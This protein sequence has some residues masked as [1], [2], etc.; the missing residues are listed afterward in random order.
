M[1][2]KSV[3]GECP[4][5]NFSDLSIICTSVKSLGVKHLSHQQVRVIVP[6]R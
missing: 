6:P 3:D 4:N 2:G 1:V 5:W